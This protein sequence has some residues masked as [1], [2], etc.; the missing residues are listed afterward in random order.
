ML[1]VSLFL[2]FVKKSE[3]NKIS[4]INIG[5]YDVSVFRSVVTVV[6]QSVF[7]SKIY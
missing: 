1:L 3:N 4:N 5:S 2:S 6:F 7:Y